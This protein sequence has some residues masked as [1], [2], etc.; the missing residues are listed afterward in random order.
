MPYGILNNEPG[1][2][3][4]LA[5]VTGIGLGALA[6]VAFSTGSYIRMRAAG[7]SHAHRQ[8][9]LTKTPKNFHLHIMKDF[10]PF[11]EPH[12]DENV[13]SAA[14]GRAGTRLNLSI[15]TTFQ[16]PGLGSRLFVGRAHDG[17]IPGCLPPGIQQLVGGLLLTSSSCDIQRANHVQTARKGKR[18][19]LV[20][21][22]WLPNTTNIR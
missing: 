17:T 3:P 8:F 22:K 10:E 13:Q 12:T 5:L 6:A 16:N 4:L 15:G 2:P 21:C 1:S 7:F 11:F 20:V 19:C 18:A 14:S 9:S